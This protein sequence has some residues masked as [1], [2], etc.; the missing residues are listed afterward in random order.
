M[1]PNFFGIKDWFCGKQFFHRLGQT[2]VGVAVRGVWGAGGWFQDNSSALYLLCI[3]F[4]L[5]LNQLHL[6]DHQALDP[7]GWGPLIEGE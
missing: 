2:G 5:L 7:G 3:L 1:V 6:S 4:L